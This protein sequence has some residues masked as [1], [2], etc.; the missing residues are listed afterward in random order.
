MPCV[1]FVPPFQGIVMSQL[2]HFLSPPMA[3][4][5]PVAPRIVGLVGGFLLVEDEP[6]RPSDIRGE[7]PA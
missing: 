6:V 5:I 4:R 7:P 2:H 3:L 1:L